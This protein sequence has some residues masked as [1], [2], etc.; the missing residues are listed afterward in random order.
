MEGALPRGGRGA[1]RAERRVSAALP[2]RPITLLEFEGQPFDPAAPVVPANCLGLLRGEGIFETFVVEDGAPSPFLERHAERLHR[3][4]EALRFDLGGRGLLEDWPAFRPR[5]AA[6]SWRV[7]YSVFRGAG[8]ELLRMWSAGPLE[9]PPPEVA[10]ALAALR[11]DPADPLVAAKTS[12][13]AREQLARRLAVEQGA[14]EALLLN[15]AGDLAECTSANVF[16]SCHGVLRT[17]SLDQGLLAG[18]TRLA[19]LEACGAAGI[20]AEEGVVAL[21]EL[22]G[23]GEVYI[24]NAVIGLIPVRAV[25]GLG[26]ELPGRRGRLLPAVRRAYLEWKSERARSV[27]NRR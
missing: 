20:P 23:A 24:T 26:L 14:W 7:R 2:L 6:G 22:R 10:L 16:V 1:G 5:L 18:T 25:V 13:R 11:R 27:P 9:S 17:P 21:D 8:D 3:S 19:V 12:S 15:L 4:A